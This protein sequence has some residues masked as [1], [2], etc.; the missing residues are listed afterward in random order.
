MTYQLFSWNV[1]GY[2]DYAHQWLKRYLEENGP[3]VVFITETKRREEE[4]KR[5]FSQIIHYNFLINAHTPANYHGV[6]MLI[7]KPHQ[8]LHVPINMNI[9]IRKDTKGDEAGIG[10]IL[11]IQ[12]NNQIN[13]LGCYTPNSGYGLKNLDYRTKIWDPA[14]FYLLELLR[15]SGPTVWMGDINVASSDIDVSDPV[16]MSTWAGFTLQERDNFNALLSTG[17]WFDPWRL[18]HPTTR[19]YTWVGYNQ[20]QRALP[21]LGMRIDNM[22]VSDTLLSKVVETYILRDDSRKSDHVPTVMILNR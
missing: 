9:P 2:D 10:R 12:L 17:H 5:Y 11:A 22:I 1:D 7:K 19:D 18:Q 8:F 4:L 3:D 21:C 15:N 14:F 20:R 6:A 16:G 13:I